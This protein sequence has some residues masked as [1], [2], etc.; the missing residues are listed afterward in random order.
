MAAADRRDPLP[1]F[2]PLVHL[3]SLRRVPGACS[4]PVPAGQLLVR[5][6]EP[7]SRLYLVE[8]GALSLTSI[9]PSGRRAIVA[10]LGPGDTFGLEGLAPDPAAQ[11]VRLHV[12]AR[13]LLPSVV[14]SVPIPSLYRAM[15][16][17]P[18]LARWIAASA[19]RRVDPVQRRLARTLTRTVKERVLGALVD[20]ASTHGRSASDEIRIDL[21][22][23]Q[24]LLASMAGATRE[25]VNRALRDLAAEGRI[26]RQRRSYR[27]P[28]G[29]LDGPGSS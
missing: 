18:D 17:R 24:E 6:G 16:S 3:A 11:G 12:E 26:R 10:V 7:A 1:L 23:T 14:L 25:S 20:L 2:D 22:V 8:T 19:A 28:R 27:L 21:P 29:Q 13:A 9:S 15:G 4:R 5:E